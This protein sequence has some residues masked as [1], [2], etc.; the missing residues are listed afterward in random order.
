VQVVPNYDFENES[1]EPWALDGELSGMSAV[2]EADSP[3][4]GSTWVAQLGSPDY[5]ASTDLSEEGTVPV[6]AVSISQTVTVPDTSE[7]VA[8]SL[9]LWYRIFTYD[10]LWSAWNQRYYDTFD[11]KI[12]SADGT[13][14]AL[15]LRDGNDAGDDPQLGIDYGVL[16][17][18]GWRNR[19]IDLGAYAGQTIQIVLAN[20]NR[21]DHH[22]NTWTLVDD[23]QIVD[24][25]GF[26]RS[27][28]P[29]VNG[30]GTGGASAAGVEQRSAPGGPRP[31]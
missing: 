28:L 8:P 7:M 15:V 4:G 25:Q 26:T 5:G 21:W 19:I 29:L 2:V 1:F 18:L 30:R 12:H 20:H 27:Y 24:W 16:K 22:Y 9:T 14:L 17:D 3:G 13:E 23:V 6:G 11:V 10:V 31:R